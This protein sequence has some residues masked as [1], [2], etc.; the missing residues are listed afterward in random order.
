MALFGRHKHHDE[1]P[2]QPLPPPPTTADLVTAARQF[3]G[4]V[5]R[6][7][8]DGLGD[9]VRMAREM[10]QMAMQQTFAVQQATA[11]TT[12]GTTAW[13]RAVMSIM[14]PPGPGFVKRCE[15]PT[16]GAPK[17]LPNVTA[18]VY[19]D[20]C[21]SLADFDLRRACENDVMPGPEYRTIV[22]GVQPQLQAALAA[23]DR[24]GYC[25]VQ[26]AIFQAYVEHVPN[27]VSHRARN[28]V[29]YR[30][31]YVEYMARTS[32]V[33]A[34]DPESAQLT[35][36]MQQR[37]A[38]LRYTSM[39]PTMVDPA[40]FWPMTETLARQLAVGTALNKATGVS[41]IDPDRS[42][43]ISEKIGWSTFCQ[44]WLPL[45]PDDAA[46]LL[47]ERVGLKNDYVAVQPVDGHD[48]TCSGCGGPIHALQGAKAVVCDQCGRTLD[49][50]SAEIPCTNCGGTMTLPQGVDQV[51]CPFCHANVEKVGIL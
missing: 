32:T 17:R 44:G 11:G 42:G 46:A 12:P 19:C 50:G 43:A 30:T 33:S 29:A 37:V 45:L 47:I 10:Q 31:Q 39:M 28:D 18:Y 14:A 16:C 34:F 13:A 6:S 2:D 1:A 4:V 8:Q 51:S 20:Y 21:G 48:R 5:H 23:G 41:D 40:T 26:R 38:G 27:A 7:P 24:D 35:A 22:N 9:M 36:E 3:E 49:V 15:C 25:A